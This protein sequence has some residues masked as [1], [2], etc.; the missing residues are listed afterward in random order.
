MPP[1]VGRESGAGRERS[2]RMVPVFCASFLDV[3]PG[4]VFW[5]LITFVCLAFLLRWKAW[6][7]ILRA[8]DER[9]KSIREA[10]EGA[11]RDREEAQRLMDEHRDDA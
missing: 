6:G 5:T 9:E 10:V 3:E 8:V 1:A 2:P 11:K 7:P 4:L